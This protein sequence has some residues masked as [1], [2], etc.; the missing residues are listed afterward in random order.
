MRPQQVPQHYLDEFCGTD[1]IIACDYLL[2]QTCP[3]TCDFAGKYHPV[4]RAEF[5]RQQAEAMA[6]DKLDLEV[7]S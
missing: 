6:L 3:R 5:L 1:G 2:R 4:E 7:G